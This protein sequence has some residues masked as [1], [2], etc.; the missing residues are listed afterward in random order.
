MTYFAIIYKTFTVDI[1]ISI[2]FCSRSRNLVHI[3]RRHRY[4]LVE[5]FVFA[6][7][8]V[9]ANGGLW[10]GTPKTGWMLVPS[11]VRQGEWE[12]LLLHPWV[13]VSPYH[14][15]LDAS[16]FLCLFFMLDRRRPLSRWTILASAW[17]GQMLAVWWGEPRLESLGLCGLS[18]IGHG[19]FAAV[20]VQW[21]RQPALVRAGSLL[22]IGLI[23][24]TM[25]EAITGQV[26][27]SSLHAGPVGHPLTLCHAGGVLGG[28]TAALLMHGI[29]TLWRPGGATRGCKN[30]NIQD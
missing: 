27:L 20:C 13:H 12:R 10:S 18:G 16:A 14:A 2:A 1:Y 17:A 29:G 5:G 22:L 11:A 6:A 3:M 8:L 25:W 4:G 19:L 9:A 7:L 21:C 15:V 23:A 30:N 26:F 24:K 28:F